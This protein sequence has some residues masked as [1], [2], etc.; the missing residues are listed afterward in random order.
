MT[1]TSCFWSAAE[2]WPAAGLRPCASGKL[3]QADD[4]RVV[5]TSR[6]AAIL[7]AS[8]GGEYVNLVANYEGGGPSLR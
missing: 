7:K 6:D 3:A 8:R 2:A 5:D 4:S 1:D